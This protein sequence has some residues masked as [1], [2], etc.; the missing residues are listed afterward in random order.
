MIRYLAH[1]EEAMR[2]RGLP[3]AWIEDTIVSPDWTTPDPGHPDRTRSFKM[4]EAA[5]SRVLRVVHWTDWENVVVL[6]AMLDRDALRQRSR[7]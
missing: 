7:P 5:G 3:P 6:T 1:A 2:R 4:L